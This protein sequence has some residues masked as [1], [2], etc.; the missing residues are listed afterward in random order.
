M[1]LI[2]SLPI[3]TKTVDY[4]G[5]QLTVLR[6]IKYLAADKDGII[7]AYL[8]EPRSNDGLWLESSSATFDYFSMPVAIVDLKD[9]DW[10]DTL[11]KV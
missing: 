5:I 1:K 3:E 10:K 9:I 7:Y 6:F 11:V 4:F 2:K 8:K